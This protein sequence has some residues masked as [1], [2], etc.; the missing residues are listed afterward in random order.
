MLTRCTVALL[1]LTGGLL[2]PARAQVTMQ[3]KFEKGEVFYVEDVQNSKMDISILGNSQKQDMVQTT[4]AKFTILDKSDSGIVMERKIESFKIAGD[5]PNPVADDMAKQM[6][7]LTFKITFKPNMEVAKIDGL[8]EFLSKLGNANPLI[9][10]AIKQMFS[11]DTLKAGLADAFGNLP[12]SPVAVGDKWSRKS[13]IPLGPMGMITTDSTYTYEGAQ[14]GLHKVGFKGVL[15]YK[16]P[17]PGEG[18]IAGAQITKAD[19]KAD[20]AKGT[21]FYDAA[22]GKIVR[23][24]TKM[25]MKMSMTATAG[26]MNLQMEMDQDMTMTSRILDKPPSA[27]A[28]SNN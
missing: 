17:K 2:A 23:S 19:L 26:G 13:N 7:G 18:G 6:Q 16:P 20:E 24:E 3:W 9:G 8:D 27:G 21:L 28:N 10:Q 11:E 15:S 1:L 25:K 4:V 12:S 5:A 22:K 14:D